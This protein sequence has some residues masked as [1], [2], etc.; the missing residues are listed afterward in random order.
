M[1]SKSM[2][3]LKPD[4]FRNAILFT[5]DDRRDSEAAEAALVE[6][7]RNPI[8]RS[9]EEIETKFMAEELSNMPNPTAE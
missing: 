7:R 3:M 6:Y 5:I 9:L 1:V 4:A 2:K 8:S